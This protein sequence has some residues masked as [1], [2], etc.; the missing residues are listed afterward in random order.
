MK[1]KD[2]IFGDSFTLKALMKKWMCKC[3]GEEVGQM[4]GHGYSNLRNHVKKGKLL[5]LLNN[6]AF[7]I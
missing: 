5:I 1:L 3:C 6:Q 7:Y 4:L 2:Q